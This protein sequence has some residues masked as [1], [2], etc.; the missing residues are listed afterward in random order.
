[1]RDGGC[2]RALLVVVAAGLCELLERAAHLAGGVGVLEPAGDGLEP[3]DAELTGQGIAERLDHPAPHVAAVVVEVGGKPVER[4]GAA[5][6]R[7][8]REDVRGPAAA[9][10][11]RLERRDGGR[12]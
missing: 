10:E 3:R 4:A 12:V 7:Q 6:R 9:A 1:R 2:G 8:G 5:A 11:P